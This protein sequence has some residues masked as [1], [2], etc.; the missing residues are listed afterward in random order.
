MRKWWWEFRQGYI[1]S[2][3]DHSQQQL[4]EHRVI[5]VFFFVFSLKTTKDLKSI[6]VIFSYVISCTNEPMNQ[7]N[8]VNKPTE[9]M[10]TI[11]TKTRSHLFLFD[12]CLCVV[13]SARYSCVLRL[14]EW[15]HL[16][17]K[18]DK[19]PCHYVARW[20]YIWEIF[21]VAVVVRRR[22]HR[23]WCCCWLLA[24]GCAQ[25]IAVHTFRTSKYS[26]HETNRR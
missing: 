9:S 7:T 8:A 26:T 12:F 23:C 16:V 18:T 4:T 5:L 10:K 13:V 25:T 1:D 19:R 14:N 6:L 2:S 24:I 21:F 22:R 3:M 15:I 17:E 20:I 11:K